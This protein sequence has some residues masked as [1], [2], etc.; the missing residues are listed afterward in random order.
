MPY[1]SVLYNIYICANNIFHSNLIQNI[2][3]VCVRA[4]V[5]VCVC[6]CVCV[7]ELHPLSCDLLSFSDDGGV[8]LG[9]L[10]H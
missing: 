10:C 2:W 1:M 4:R 7:I 9:G 6:V 5:C 8:I 3:H